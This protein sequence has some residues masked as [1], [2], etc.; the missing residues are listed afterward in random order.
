[1]EKTWRVLICGLGIVVF[2]LWSQGIS[3]ARSQKKGEVAKMEEVVVTATRVKEAA[4]GL[5][6][7]TTVISSQEIEAQ[8]LETVADVLR[9]VEGLYIQ[10][11]GGPGRTTSLRIRGLDSRWVM[12]MVDG[13]EVNDPSAIGGAF[14]FSDLTVD[15]IDRIEIVRGPA[16]SLYGSDAMA[17]VINIITKRG[18]GKPSLTFSGYIGSMDTWQARAFS[19]GQVG[20]LDYSFSASHLETN[21]VGKDDRYWNSSYAFHVGTDLLEN[22]RLEGTVRFVNGDVQYDDYDWFRKKAVNDPNQWQKRDH[23]I[24][25]FKAT[26]LPFDWWES[27][28]K[29]GMSDTRRKYND[30]FDNESMD[31]QEY[32]SSW[33]TFVTDQLKSEQSYTGRI[34]KIDWQNTFY[35]LD[36][37]NVKDTLVVGYE[38]REDE[39]KSTSY[40]ETESFSNGWPLGISVNRSRFSFRRAQLIGYYAQNELRLWDSLTLLAGMRIDDPDD[41]GG[42]TTY[43]LG[44]SYH[45]KKTDTIFRVRFATAFKAPTLY[46]LYAPP[47]PAWYFLGGNR[48]L[49]PERAQSYEGGITQYLFHRKVALDLTAFREAVKN[50]ILYVYDPVTWYGTYENIASVVDRGVEAGLTLRPLDNLVLKANYTYV[51]PE[52]RE[53]HRRVERVP[54]NQWST[55]VFYTWKNKLKAYLGVRFVGDRV[56]SYGTN[57]TYYINSYTVVDGKVSYQVGKHFQVFLRGEN[58]FNRKYEEVKGYEAPGASWYLGGKVQ[59]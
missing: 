1:M 3:L 41:F 58:M 14:D 39:G 48:N 49:S 42:R 57:K 11:T 22:L 37:K 33:G 31:H 46:E 19:Q 29:M 35:V 59:F 5:P 27:Q 26:Y 44:A 52:D 43:N 6:I 13:M 8:G 16:S 15:D 40:I 45:L 51:D 4:E 23:L 47:N 34:K 20:L 17:G 25:T 56:D 18:R 38:Y 54:L 10:N 9:Y 55:S 30:K 24:L 32:S 2:M 12:V 53:H 28:L 21:G 7:S 50:K 36:R